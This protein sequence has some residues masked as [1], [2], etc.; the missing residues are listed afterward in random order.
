MKD[1]AAAIFGIVTILTIW[2]LGIAIGVA[3]VVYITGQV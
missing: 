3:A 2:G 1:A